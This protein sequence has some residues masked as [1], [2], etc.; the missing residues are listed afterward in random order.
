[1]GYQL[2]FQNK[3]LHGGLFLR[4]ENGTESR[5]ELSYYIVLLML[6]SG[7]LI[8]NQIGEFCNSEDDDYK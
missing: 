3:T 4:I 7:L 5:D 8:A 2:Y 1:M 6:K